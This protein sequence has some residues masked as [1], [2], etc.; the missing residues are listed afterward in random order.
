MTLLAALAALR[1]DGATG[2]GCA[3]P[4]PGDPVGSAGPRRFN[5]AALE[6]GEAVVVSGQRTR[7]WCRPGSAPRS[8]GRRSRRSRA[9]SP[10]S[11]RP[12]ASCAPRCSTPPTDWPTL[13][14]AHWRPE[15][16]DELMNLR[17]PRPVAAPPGIPGR[18]LDLAGRGLQAMTIVDLALADDG[19][20]LS[21]H[22]I[23]QRAGRAGAAGPRR[24]PGAGRRL[25]PR[26]LAAA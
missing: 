22:E 23:G 13:D 21:A 15:V 24:A 25:L 3:A 20:A 11:A 2:F 19:G 14:V 18:C 17:H 9:R 10:T 16:A 7:A 26:G 12:I 1:V 8:S 6:A 4:A 5:A